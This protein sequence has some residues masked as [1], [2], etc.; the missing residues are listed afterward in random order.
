MRRF[1]LLFALLALAVA[2]R[3]GGGYD[4][5]DDKTLAPHFP[6]LNGEDYAWMRT[7]VS[8]SKPEARAYLTQLVENKSHDPERGELLCILK[9]LVLTTADKR[10]DPQWSKGGWGSNSAV[11]IHN[12]RVD[13]DGLASDPA[14]TPD[15]LEI[16]Q[17]RLAMY[18]KAIGDAQNGTVRV[19]SS[20]MTRVQA[21]AER[22]RIKDKIEKLTAAANS[23]WHGLCR[24][25]TNYNTAM[26]HNVLPLKRHTVKG[27]SLYVGK[28][29]DDH[30]HNVV[31]V[32][33][34]DRKGPGLV[35]DAWGDLRLMT[36]KEFLA[37]G[38]Y[39]YDTAGDCD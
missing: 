25:W 28:R 16:L 24:D 29:G 32:C 2:A 6:H 20:V 37:S 39:L 9:V 15:N 33:G 36:K 18:E 34:L 13:P 7:M 35:L 14:A 30:E 23:V 3:A 31:L 8:W 5:P 12:G 17:R 1:F 26:V 4:C 21:Q 11:N 19:Q 38:N 10:K 22:D 27:W